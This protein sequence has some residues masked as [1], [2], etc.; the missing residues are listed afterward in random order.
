M[1]F[2]NL[3]PLKRGFRKPSLPF[4]SWI[5]ASLFHIYRRAKRE[6]SNPWLFTILSQEVFDISLPIGKVTS[7]DSR[8]TDDI[9]F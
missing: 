3:V 1:A 2:G 5:A 4:A 7:K 9:G 6:S 8:T